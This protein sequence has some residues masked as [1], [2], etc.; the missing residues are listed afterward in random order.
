VKAQFKY[1]FLT[2]LY[3]RGAAFAVIMAM[4]L[5]F[6]VLGSCGLLP[7]AANV[8]AVSLGGTAIA[9]MMA[10]NIVS[11]VMI[12]RR[13]FA[14]PSAYIYALAPV[15]RRK[16]LLSAVVAITVTDVI[17]MTGVIAGV[18]WNSLILASGYTTET[19]WSLVRPGI[20]DVLF[21]LS[22]IA[23]FI[24]GY[25]LLIMVIMFCVTIRK[26]VFDNKPA[27]FILSILTTAGVCV[28]L[29]L[30]SFLLVPFGTVSRFAWY[31]TVTVGQSGI[32]PYTLL[33]LLQA[34]ALF[35]VTTKL[36]ERKIN[37]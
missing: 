11:N 21:M 29:N 3:T 14:A 30:T 6:I 5:V 34:A 32:I 1:A 9:V 33:M 37:I 20:Q 2:G 26:S 17:T 10:I 28:L 18:V 12:T 23:L 4:N 35:V 8:T 16:M 36:M 13:I 25:V 19:F 22:G 31:F 15:P 24:S 27:G 7:F